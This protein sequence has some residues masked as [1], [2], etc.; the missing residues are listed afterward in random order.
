[1]PKSENNGAVAVKKI[2][3][4]NNGKKSTENVYNLDQV[5]MQ[6]LNHIYRAEEELNA[7]FPDLLKSV[8]DE[9]LEETLSDLHQQNKRQM[10]RLEKIM[11]RYSFKNTQFKVCEVM[12][13]QIEETKRM[14]KQFSS[15]A[16]CDAALII[17]I[18]KILHHKIATYGSICEIADVL[19]Y[20]RIADMLDRTLVDCENADASLT[21]L[22]EEVNSDAFD[23]LV[24]GSAH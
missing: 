13:A 10:E 20:N 12:H 4:S 21:R 22:A 11:T 2:K 16:A 17:Q 23:E 18:Q 19:G 8:S 6:E 14:M 9:D 3:L 15:G 1:M 24:E 7:F 5:I